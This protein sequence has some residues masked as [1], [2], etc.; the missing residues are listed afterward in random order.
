MRASMLARGEPLAR[1]GAL[2]KD[3][4]AMTRLIAKPQVYVTEAD[5]E[6]LDALVGDR[7]GPMPG[8]RLLRGELDRAIVVGSLEAPTRF[9]R[10]NSEVSFRDG[11]SGQARTVRLVGPAEADVDR[12]R[13]SVLSPV[14]AALFGLTRGAAFGWVDDGGRD[15]RIEILDVGDG[16]ADS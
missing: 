16:H 12:N 2:M 9:V 4:T 10:L 13:I 3:M 1:D 8:P 5:L 6:L 15:H 11:H 14:G 7:P